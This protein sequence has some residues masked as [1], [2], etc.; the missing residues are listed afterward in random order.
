ME[1][2]WPMST[3]SGRA[4]ASAILVW[5]ARS[6]AALVTSAAGVEMS[7]AARCDEA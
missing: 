5:N 4:V 2:S 3:S 6:R 1:P 7:V